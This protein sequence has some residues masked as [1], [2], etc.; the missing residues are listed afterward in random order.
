M[1]QKRRPISGLSHKKAIIPK[2]PSYFNESDKQALIQDYLRSNC[3]K[4]E[5]W[6]RYTGKDD[7]GVLVKWM[8]ELGYKDTKPKKNH[9]FADQ[10]N[11]GVKKKRDNKHLQ[12]EQFE[13]LR[14]KK[15]ILELEG[16]LKDAEMQ[17]IA[18]STMVDIAEQEFNVPIRKKFNTKP[19]KK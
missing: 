5:I 8:R 15:R 18:F 17:A 7:H 19:S 3:K 14:L 13:M 1:K 6:K 16:Q 9:N 12:D 10:N 4:Q 11:T 2:P